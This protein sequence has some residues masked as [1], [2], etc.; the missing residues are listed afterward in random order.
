MRSASRQYLIILCGL[1]MSFICIPVKPDFES[2]SY[3]A[4][5]SFGNM[6]NA[7]MPN[8]PPSS[9]S[10]LQATTMPT[11]MAKVKSPPQADPPSQCFTGERERRA[12]NQVLEKHPSKG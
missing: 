7:S 9:P 3:Q 1:F 5:F 2:V 4:A 10:M 6:E 8:L 12:C 11:R